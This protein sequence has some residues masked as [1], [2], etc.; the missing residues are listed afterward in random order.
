MAQ[1]PRP[2]ALLLLPITAQ[3]HTHTH[4]LLL[5]QSG[6][7]VQALPPYPGVCVCVCAP[8]KLALMSLTEF[9]FVG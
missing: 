5:L 7:P 9:V 1:L 3:V 8:R 4:A 6:R 2:Q